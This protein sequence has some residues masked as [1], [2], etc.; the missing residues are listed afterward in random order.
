MITRLKIA[1][2]LFDARHPVNFDLRNNL[3]LNG[4]IALTYF[5]TYNTVWGI[6]DNLFDS[7]AMSVANS[8]PA[9]S[10]LNSNNGYHNT[11]NL[12]A[13]SRGDVTV[14]NTDYQAG[15]L[16][17]FYY[18]ASGT[19]LFSLVNAGSRT[20]DQAGLYHYTTQTSQ[21]KET[22]SLVDIGYHFVAFANNA[23]IDTDGDGI[24]DYFEDRNGNGSVDT[25]ETDW[26]T[27]NSSITGA[28][29]LQV[30]TP[31]K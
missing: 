21:A 10:P 30:F 4:T 6:Y 7:V 27:S 14:T 22:N 24:A 18:P 31:L 28:A 19:N 20:A 26:Q 15:P 25:G 16:G 3:F 2:D 8:N 17:N 9:I 13:S 12:P 23:P 1:L 29:G 5:N 11:T